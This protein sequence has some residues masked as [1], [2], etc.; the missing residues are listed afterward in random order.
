MLITR[1]CIRAQ[2]WNNFRLKLT[3]TYVTSST[4]HNVPTSRF[5]GKDID[6]ARSYCSNIIQKFDSP[7]YILQTF[8]PIGSR[9]VYLSLRAL[10]VELARIPDLISN[11]KVGALRMEFWRSSII[12]TF[13]GMPPREPVAILLSNALAS[14]QLHHT[15]L[16]TGMMK[17]WCIKII[18]AREKYMDNRP[19]TSMEALETYAEN[20]YSNLLYITLAALPVHSLII[21]HIASHIGKANG[22][23]TVLKGLPL[24]AFP[25]QSNHHNNN[26][27]FRASMGGK[28][29]GGREAIIL[30]LNVMAEAGVKEEEIYRHGSNAPGLKDA[31]FAVA[32]RAND[33]LI[34]AKE[35]LHRARLG[36]DVGHEYE[37]AHEEGHNYLGQDSSSSTIAD[38]IEKSFGVFM[39]AIATKLWLEKL[40]KLDFDI[41]DPKLRTREWRLPWKS[42][43]A[44][45]QRM[46]L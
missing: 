17:A 29:D 7:S 23:A 1:F 31:V 15:D 44:Y 5:T 20:T 27:A 28:L 33:H 12:K 38:L 9:D 10:N 30:P 13:E 19:Y 43:W 3:C 14:L 40:E 24:I 34:T 37:H 26:V 21:D 18:N 36:Q 22:I 39:P 2:K 6:M 32:T 16:R 4:L 25:T 35:M 11:P 8:I 42:F 46:L 45:S 41:F